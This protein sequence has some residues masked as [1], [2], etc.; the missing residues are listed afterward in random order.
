MVGIRH[1]GHVISTLSRIIEQT[2]DGFWVCTVT[3]DDEDMIGKFE[4]LRMKILVENKVDDQKM[5]RNYY[6]DRLLSSDQICISLLLD[7]KQENAL[8]F[9]T[10]LHRPW[11]GNAVRVLN[12]LYFD[13]EIR[14]WGRAEKD[15][16]YRCNP[17]DIEVSPIMVD[18]QLNFIEAH[19]PDVAL[20]FISKEPWKTRWCKMVAEDFT[21]KCLKGDHPLWQVE[22][23]LYP[24]IENHE[25]YSCWQHVIYK[26]ISK[27]VDAYDI[28][29][30][31]ITFNEFRE[32]FKP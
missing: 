7:E 8:A 32:R 2:I 13:P 11:F 10:A 17:R 1:R 19:M 30:K 15:A 31:G 6:Y 20:M 12:R 24:M 14:I 21:Q 4:K 25:E 16:T 22:D 18:Q 23:Y 5:I 26:C 29:Q 3:P 28:L 27:D 9:S